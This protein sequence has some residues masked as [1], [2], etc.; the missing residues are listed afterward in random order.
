MDSHWGYACGI[1]VV[2]SKDARKSAVGER[3]I[4]DL[5]VIYLIHISG[6]RVTSE[7]YA[8]FAMFPRSIIVSAKVRLKAVM[9][10]VKVFTVVKSE[11]SV[12]YFKE[13]II[14]DLVSVT[15]DLYEHYTVMLQV[16]KVAVVDMDTI[17][18]P[19]NYSLSKRIFENHV[20]H[21][22]SRDL[23]TCSGATLKAYNALYAGP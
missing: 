11:P 17:A 1:L 8:V 23:G 10:N 15:G 21:V 22:D 20:M 7:L 12:S 18:P 5:D 19:D 2:I 16:L 6:I 9:M 14:I 3:V 4:M 13:L